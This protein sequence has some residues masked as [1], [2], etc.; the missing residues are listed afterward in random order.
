MTAYAQTNLQLFDQ[1]HRAGYAADEVVRLRRAYDLARRLFVGLHLPSGKPF[2]DHAVGTASILASLAAPI[3]VVAAGLLHAAYS[4]GDFGTAGRGAAGAKRAKIARAVGA[5]VEERIARYDAMTW[6]SKSIPA[7]R[8]GLR[9]FDRLG[10]E[11][12]LVRLANELEHRLDLADL[13][14]GKRSWL[15]RYGEL[16]LDTMLEMARGL[17][18]SCLAEE[19]ARAFAAAAAAAIPAEAES[20]SGQTRSYVAA[21]RSYRRRRWIALRRKLIDEISRLRIALGLRTRFRRFARRFHP[22]TAS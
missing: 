20:R 6:D 13:Y 16:Y 14:A 21:P 3:E 19:L 12:L 8:A 18:F 7:I 4:N 9:G 5:P 22:E 2:L 17:G 10:R 11:V 1:L 15:Q